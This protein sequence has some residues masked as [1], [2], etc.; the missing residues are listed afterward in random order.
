MATNTGIE[1][2]WVDA[3]ND[4]YDL[5]GDRH[6]VKCQLPDFTVVDVEACKGWLQDSVYE[7]HHVRVETGWV[8]GKPGVVAARWRDTGAE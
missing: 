2:R 7:G 8:L 4:L 3:W 6:G 5:I 1:M